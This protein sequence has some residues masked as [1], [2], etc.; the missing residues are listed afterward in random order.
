MSTGTNNDFTHQSQRQ[1]F[2]NFLSAERVR[3]YAMPFLVANILVV[4]GC[5]LADLFWQ[6]ESPLLG[7]DFRVFWAASKLALNGSGADVYDIDRLFPIQQSIAPGLAQAKPWQQWFYPPPFLLAI[8]PL[9]LIPY[10]PSFLL[11]NA[12]GILFYL[13]VLRLVVTLRGAIVISLSAP[14]VLFTVINGQNSFFTAGLAGL[15]LTLLERRPSLAGTLIGLLIIKPHLA[16]LF[17]VALIAGR[18]WRTLSWAAGSSFTLLGAS[19]ILFS[20]QSATNFFAQIR[21]AKSFAEQGLLPIEK[22]PTVFASMRLLGL[23]ANI[24]NGVHIFVALTVT[25]VVGWLWTRRTSSD[26]R[27]AALVLGSLL[28]SPHLFDYDLVWLAWPIGWFVMHALKHG[29]KTGERLLLILAWVSP[30]AGGLLAH[31]ARIQ[32]TPLIII[33]LLAAVAR[34]AQINGRLQV[35]HMNE[36][37]CLNGGMYAPK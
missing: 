30:V 12:V 3:L 11:F 18:A 36:T 34:R 7:N 6:H 5:L 9:A 19:L 26:L 16:L 37:S 1:V 21:V 10:Y 28:I 24:A 17:V 22:M 15:G 27:K 32:I 23:Q 2:A 29:W 25:V 8:L 33:L 13:R 31:V 20:S 14:A 35:K 4:I